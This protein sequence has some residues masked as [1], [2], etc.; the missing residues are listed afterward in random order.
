MNYGS[1]RL[2]QSFHTVASFYGYQELAAIY[3]SWLGRRIVD[4]L[5]DEA[6]KKGWKLVCPSWEPDKLTRLEKYHQHLNVHELMIRALKSERCFGGS[7]IT[8]LTDDTW[9]AM[10]NPI[11]DFLPHKSLLK[12]QM[13]DAWQTYASEMN[14]MNPLK[15][16]YQF[17]ETYTIGSAGMIAM[18]QGKEDSNFITGSVV[19]HSRIERFGGEWMPWYER[20]R[21]L[22][23]GAS[24]LGIAYDA[25]RNAGTVDN[26]IASLLF[27]ASVPVFKVED[28]INIVADPEA[29]A[30]FLERMNILNY[31]MSNNNMAIID[32][33][34]EL[35]NLELGALSGLDPIL[36][37]YYIIVSAAT[38]IPVTKLVGESAKGLTA[39]G[40]G[41]LDN[42]YDLLETYR[43][44]RIKPHLMNIF[45][46][47]IIPSFYNE[48]MPA[49]F[50]I[51][52]PE[53]ERESPGKKQEKDSALIDMVIKAEDAGL[54]DKKV[55][56]LEILERKMFR[57]YTK[58]DIERIENEKVEN[59]VEM[60]D[61]LDAADELYNQEKE[62]VEK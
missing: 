16:N 32:K 60:K 10:R 52:F 5:P 53:L 19:H 13:F 48:L 25:I 1:D 34:E 54:I 56:R 62:L 43:Y 35:S 15:D 18:N 47:W 57:N 2:Q 49:D 31:Q 29:R 30:A 24:T 45:K 9:G 3:L 44:N 59:E 21:N 33:D 12:L 14:L 26:S 27:R 11:P 7:V 46:H 50:D 28:L 55:A 37:R 8:A 38:G 58:K 4:L 39:T 51:E 22:Y 41:D 17:P 20:Q 6:M 61:A 42:Y 36:E 23:W 40:E